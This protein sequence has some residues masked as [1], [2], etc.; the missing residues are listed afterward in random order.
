MTR[1]SNYRER[2]SKSVFARMVNDCPM[3]DTEPER[4]ENVLCFFNV[5]STVH[6]AEPEAQPCLME[7]GDTHIGSMTH[8]ECQ[9]ALRHIL[10]AS[11]ILSH[12][13]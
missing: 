3:Q 13:V 2:R 6:A 8:E 1:L 10:G 11:M 5:L 4:S 7:Q 9:D 12:E